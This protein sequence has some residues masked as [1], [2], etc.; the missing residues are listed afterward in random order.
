M[1]GRPSSRDVLGPVASPA[2]PVMALIPEEQLLVDCCRLE[3]DDSTRARVDA[4]LGRNLDWSYVVETAI[5][6]A[7]AP[8]LQHGLLA[9]ASEEKRRAAVPHAV[10]T[11]L[12]E[13]YRLSGIRTRRL[14]RLAGEIA[15]ILADLGIS[16]IGLKEVGLAGDVYGDPAL[17]P[18]GDLDLL[19]RRED[20]AR[21]AA[22]LEQMDFAAK[23]TR[24][25]PY[26]LK[27]GMAQHF[28][29]ASD[30]TYVDLQWNVLQRE[31]D[32]YHEGTFT[33]D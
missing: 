15:E 32:M 17:R 16:V 12:D 9:T 3:S 20:V 19:V 11:Q 2:P 26:L 4:L 29:R 1:S 22:A 27:Y 28:Y 24:D 6:H 10:Q 5:R 14:L 30:N 8:L 23:P 25:V 18:M 21:A 31:W 7:V 13:A 33:H